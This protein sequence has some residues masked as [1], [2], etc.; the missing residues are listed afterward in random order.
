MGVTNELMAFLYFTVSGMIS[1]LIFD[2]FRCKRKNFK[3]SNLLVYFED[4]IFWVIIGGIAIYTSYI[5][6]NGQV[7]VFMLISMLLGSFI[8][9]L[10][11][12]KLCYKVFENLCRYIKRLLE[13]FSK[14]LNG[15]KNEAK[16]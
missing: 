13:L 4:L 16:I 6:C 3:T 9:F 1:G 15:G 10:T 8:Y 12:G 11:F 7:R 14:I 2:L 5:S